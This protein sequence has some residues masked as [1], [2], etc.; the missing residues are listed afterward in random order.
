ME[1]ILRVVFQCCLNS[2]LAQISEKDN[3]PLMLHTKFFNTIYNYSQGGS[4]LW[5]VRVT[6]AVYWELGSKPKLFPLI[7][8]HWAGVSL[9][10]SSYEFAE[11]CELDRQALASF[12]PS[13]TVRESFPSYGFDYLT[14][15]NQSII[16][17][18]RHVALRLLS[19]SL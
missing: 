4:Y 12:P 7:F 6:A 1:N 3:F 17:F 14:W 10:T 9:Y 11:T 18:S 5:T 19:I 2:L 8:Q 16:T 13:K 15:L